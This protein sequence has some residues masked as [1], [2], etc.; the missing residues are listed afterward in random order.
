MNRSD[1]VGGPR[2]ARR[3]G[4]GFVSLSILLVLSCVPV[5]VG[6]M[7][8][9]PMLRA[10]SGSAQTQ[11]STQGRPEFEVASI[12][13]SV[14]PPG[15]RITVMMETQGERFRATH[16]PLINLIA[17]AYNVHLFQI[18]GAP[19]WVSSF[20]N[21]YEIDAK[22]GTGIST[23]ESRLMLQSLLAD[24]AKL[25]LRSEKKELAV[26]ELCVGKN[27]SKL[28]AIEP[29][30]PGDR[31]GTFG[32][33]GVLVGIKTSM[34]QLS[35]VLSMRLDRPVLNKTGINGYFDFKFE[36]APDNQPDSAAPSIFTALQ[37]QLGLKLESTKEPVEVLVL[38]HIEKPSAN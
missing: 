30:G 9:A 27:G 22:A 3:I 12:K 14:I 33:V 20:E 6:M 13:P 32:R 38:D 28:R 26:Y 36:Y 21:G 4:S 23:D 25:K 7:D 37:E 16:E 5:F 35:G 31:S 11:I 2:R 34:E 19:D 18:S 10:Q 24:R 29:P 15:G 8:L 17:F 1:G